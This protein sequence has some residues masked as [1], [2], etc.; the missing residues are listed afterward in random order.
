MSC[1]YLDVQPTS[2]GCREPPLS[3][4]LIYSSTHLSA[5]HSFDVGNRRNTSKIIAKKNFRC[6]NDPFAL[7]TRHQMLRLQ[8]QTSRNSRVRH[9]AIF[10]TSE[11]DSRLDRR[12]LPLSLPPLFS[13]ARPRLGLRGAALWLPQ[14]RLN[15]RVERERVVRQSETGRPAASA[16]I[17]LLI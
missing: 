17:Y 3:S 10:V 11:D 7:Q 2:T 13:L 12:R 1:W 15:I 14:I 5:S 8:R 9:I 16:A 6:E 4:K